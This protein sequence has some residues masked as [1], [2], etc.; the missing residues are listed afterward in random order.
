MTKILITGGTGFLGK[1]LGASLQKMGNEVVLAGRNNK[2][3]LLAAD[4]SGCPSLA[5][6]VSHIESVRDIITQVEPEVVI[7]AAATKF[8]DISE[9]QPMEAVDVNV[10]GSQNVARVAIEKGVKTVIGISTDKASPP[11]RNTYG[12]TKAL[13][14]RMF[15]GMNGKSPTQFLCVRYGNVAWSTGSVLCIWRKML[16]EKGIIGTTGPD[17]YR[18]FFTV[19]EAVD[20]VMSALKNSDQYQGKILSRRMKAAQMKDILRVWT[21]HEGGRYEIISGRPGER[22]E[23][24]LF[25]ELELPYTQQFMLNGIDHYLISFN[26]LVEEPVEDVLSSSNTDL[27]TDA[28]ILEIILNPPMEEV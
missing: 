22:N 28:E 12:L 16:K 24:Y 14:E 3:L 5:M 17:M 26:Q 25:G 13:M 9:K 2:Q 19:D 7:H 18:F 21:Q 15:C 6:D 23:E 4:F 8:V 10:V 20:L 1:R 27:L 11:V